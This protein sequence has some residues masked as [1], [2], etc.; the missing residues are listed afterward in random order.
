MIGRLI[1]VGTSAAQLRE[2]LNDTSESLRRVA[3]RVANA[4]NGVPGGSP[5][6]DE[7]LQATNPDADPSLAEEVDLEAEMVRLANEQIRYD[8]SATLLQRVYVQ[9]RASVRGV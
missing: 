9:L 1:G 2:G 8:T 6:F 4:T 7:V 5:G 3:H